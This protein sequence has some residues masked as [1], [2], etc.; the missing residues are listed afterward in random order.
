MA[1]QPYPIQLIGLN[2][3][4]N[5]FTKEYVPYLVEG[6]KYLIPSQV[7]IQGQEWV[8]VN[9][10][11]IQLANTLSTE[12]EI[13]ILDTDESSI[14]QTLT[15]IE[16][17]VGNDI[18]P[19]RDQCMWFNQNG[20]A[21]NYYIHSDWL[22]KILHIKRG[23]YVGTAVSSVRLGASGI[24]AYYYQMSLNN[25]SFDSNEAPSVWYEKLYGIKTTWQLIYNTEAIYPRTEGNN[26]GRSNGFQGDGGRN[27]TGNFRSDLVGCLSSGIGIFYGLENTNRYNTGLGQGTAQF[28]EMNIN[29]SRQIP[30]K[31]EYTVR[32]RLWRI[33]KLLKINGV[34]INKILGV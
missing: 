17:A 15:L 23:L 28:R 9:T 29:L 10:S 34:D 11:Y 32:N 3:V 14:L 2:D 1:L 19:N 20:L 13:E 8:A 31:S 30:I 5:P 16:N 22:G 7:N 21:G 25:G 24:P 12:Y 27:A 26:E 33:Y 6:A 18:K 4:Y